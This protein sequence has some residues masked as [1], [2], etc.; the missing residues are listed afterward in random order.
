LHLQNIR[1][2]TLRHIVG[3]KE[4]AEATM[5]LFRANKGDNQKLLKMET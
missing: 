1:S 3:T 2:P 5:V 4:C